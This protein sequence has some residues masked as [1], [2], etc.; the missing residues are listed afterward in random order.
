VG[1]IVVLLGLLIVGYLAKD[2]LLRYG[3]AG[4]TKVSPNE[5]TMKAGTAAER[6]RAPGAAAG[7]DAADLGNAPPTP[8]GALER[9]RGVEDMVRKAADERATRVDRASP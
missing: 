1:L 7:V 5:A 3:L 4:S 9:A 6:A 2:A 8:A